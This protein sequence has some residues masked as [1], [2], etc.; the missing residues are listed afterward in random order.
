VNPH[1]PAPGRRLIVNA[2]DLGQSPGVNRGVF[3]AA[4]AGIV[5]SASLMVMWPSAQAAVDGA[6]SRPG[7]SLGLHVDLG[8]WAFRDG[9]WS[10]L[11]RI[12]DARDADSVAAELAQQVE[13]F[14]RMVGRSPT[15]FDSHQHLH[16]EEPLRSLVLASADRMGAQV[17][18]ESSAVTYC[19]SFYGQYGPG[20]PYPEGITVDALLAIIDELPA[21]TTEL[22]CHPGAGTVDELDS[23]YVTEREVELDT[24]CD[25]RIRSALADRQIELCSFADLS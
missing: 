7:L 23:M 11:Y 24:L 16:R 14:C 25:P 17:R 12:T 3:R 15:H 10:E 19:G 18:G 4:D 13:A 21:G 1:Q 6:R 5:T 2:D 20:N 22:G 9:A 8:E